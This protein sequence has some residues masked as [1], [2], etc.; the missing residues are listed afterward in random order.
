M[1]ITSTRTTVASTGR[2][3]LLVAVL[4]T[5]ASPAYTQCSDAG[6]CAVRQPESIVAGQ[7]S[8]DRT[9][10]PGNLGLLYRY[11]TS[12]SVNDDDKI[13]YHSIELAGQV[14]L[15]AATRV[16]AR[17]PYR[18]QSG[19]AG[20]V[21]GIGDLL[22][23]LEQELADFGAF[24]SYAALGTRLATGDANAD[25][26]LPQAY[27]PGLGTNDLLLGLGLRSEAWSFALGYQLVE[28][29]FTDNALTPI[30]RGDDFYVQIGHSRM[31]GPVALRFDLQGIQ[32][33]TTTELRADDES[34]L[35][36][37]DTDQLQINLGA[38]GSVPLGRTTDLRLGLAVPLMKRE[39]NID[40]LR[41]A[42]TVWVGAGLAF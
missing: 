30:R 12:G 20:S 19:A 26:T 25:A 35:E 13:N 11:G 38:E 29:T 23:L 31:A 18:H 28:N 14:R 5:A 36:V 27:Q 4:L 24:A 6:I 10:S 41:R 42:L 1:L 2:L 7:S 39:S 9:A 21:S 15:G 3:I 34:I 32:R 16:S 40:G 37:D 8:D 33:L 17:L 22:I